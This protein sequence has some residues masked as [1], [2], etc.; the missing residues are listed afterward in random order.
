MN[1]LIEL[2]VE[3]WI[4]MIAAQGKEKAQIDSVLHVVFALLFRKNTSHTND[5]LGNFWVQL[6]LWWLQSENSSLVNAAL[7][8][9]QLAVKEVIELQAKFPLEYIVSDAEIP[10]CNG[11][12]V[13]R[14]ISNSSKVTWVKEK[15]ADCG[16]I[17]FYRCRM[18]N[19]YRWWYISE[20]VPGHESAD[21]DIDYYFH[22]GG[23]IEEPLRLPPLTG[24]KI[25]TW[26]RKGTKDWASSLPKI[27]SRG[28]FLPGGI[29]ESIMFKAM[30]FQLFQSI[31]N[32]HEQISNFLRYNSRS[33]KVFLNSRISIGISDQEL[34][35]YWAA[36]RDIYESC[37]A[38]LKY[39]TECAW[40]SIC[41]ELSDAQF[42]I[43]FNLVSL[44]YFANTEIALNMLSLAGNIPGVGARFVKLII[45]AERLD[46]LQ[47]APAEKLK[48]FFCMMK[49]TSVAHQIIFEKAHSD[50]DHPN[51]L[52][53]PIGMDIMKDPVLCAD[54]H[55]Y[56]RENIE[57]WLATRDT[58]PLTNE[59]LENKTL[60]R[61]HT[62]RA[63]LESYTRRI[64]SK[65]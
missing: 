23:T 25:C 61:N 65:M 29:D 63:I 34:Q 21:G 41:S 12:Y 22:D 26:P 1:R 11:V 5:T 42:E 44:D 56:E 64:Q 13:A 19:R 17:V 6:T 51:S 31:G 24:W 52:L 48:M 10:Q 32:T 50:V 30:L 4:T 27:S 28:I 3:D 53:C 18:R 55:S 40:V 57:R 47:N 7:K 45:Q 8:S 54:G 2:S 14:D 59:K 43:L 15:T 58:S 36:S 49:S 46:Q 35:D 62:L 37:T 20:P 38:D 16:E 33:L 39:Q 60:I 9:V